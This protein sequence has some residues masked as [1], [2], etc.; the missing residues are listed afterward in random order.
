[1][2][3]VRERIGER[4]GGGEGGGDTVVLFFVYFFV[5]GTCHHAALGKT[6]LVLTQGLWRVVWVAQRTL[7]VLYKSTVLLGAV[8]RGRDRPGRTDS[9]VGC[10]S[11]VPPCFARFAVSLLF[12]VVASKFPST[13]IFF[14]LVRC[15]L[16]AYCS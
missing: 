10:L 14:V 4:T 7:M 2:G 12:V 8:L 9:R 3:G 11:R 5:R 1:M 16:A 15:V 13:H 6:W